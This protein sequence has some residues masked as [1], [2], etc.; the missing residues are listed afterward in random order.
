MAEQGTPRAWGMVYPHLGHRQ[1]EEPPSPRP[2][3]PDAEKI[4]SSLSIRL[5]SRYFIGYLPWLWSSRR[6]TDGA[7]PRRGNVLPCAPT[8]SASSPDTAHRGDLL[9]PRPRGILQA[10]AH[11]GMYALLARVSRDSRRDYG[12]LT[13]TASAGEAEGA[14]NPLSGGQPMGE[15]GGQGTSP[16]P[17]G[18]ERREVSGRRLKAA[19]SPD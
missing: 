13:K 11:N 6:G 9:C 18:L 10:Y 17:T 12:H 4:L 1:T 14:R 16:A 2:P 8:P 19:V 3:R 15:S 5:S 7:A